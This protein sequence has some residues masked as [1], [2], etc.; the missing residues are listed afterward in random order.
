MTDGIDELIPRTRLPVDSVGTITVP[1]PV[2]RLSIPSRRLRYIMLFAVHNGGDHLTKEIR[3]VI[4][5]FANYNSKYGAKRMIGIKLRL[6]NDVTPRVNLT[7]IQAIYWDAEE[8]VYT[9]LAN[10]QICL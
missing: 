10:R 2:N 1:G 9:G 4:Q 3:Y 7:G 8:P 5:R 6:F